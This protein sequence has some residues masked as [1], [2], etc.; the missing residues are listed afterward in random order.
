MMITRLMSPLIWRMI[1]QYSSSRVE[2]V[3]SNL[4]LAAIKAAQTSLAQQTPVETDRIE[5]HC[6][7][8]QTVGNNKAR[9]TSFLELN[10][11]LSNRLFRITI[12]LRPQFELS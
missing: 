9:L 5:H 4:T 12:Q 10:Q 2:F 8:K 3:E 6:L 11:K 1:T 7:E